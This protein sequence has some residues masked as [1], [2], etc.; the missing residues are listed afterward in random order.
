MLNELQRQRGVDPKK[1]KGALTEFKATGIVP[2][3]K[4]TLDERTAFVV[5]A[6]MVMALEW[7]RTQTAINNAFASISKEAVA[8][9]ETD[10]DVEKAVELVLEHLHTNP[11]KGTIYASKLSMTLGI[12][13][14]IVDAAL[15]K[16]K[17]E[18]IIES[19]GA[20]KKPAPKPK[21]KPVKKGKK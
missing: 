15:A 12:P 2:T 21:K 14:P 6:H 19:Q 8:S 10:E 3:N 13:K 11:P 4:L 5:G 7:M 18:G 20:S 9:T 16:L 17:E 1:I